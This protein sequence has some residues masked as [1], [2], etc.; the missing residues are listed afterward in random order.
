MVKWLLR[1]CEDCG[2]YTL[3]TVLC[4]TCGGKVRIPHPAKFSPD[5]KYIQYR[6]LKKIEDETAPSSKET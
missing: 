4:P 3:N 5:D 2:K 1:R 6:T